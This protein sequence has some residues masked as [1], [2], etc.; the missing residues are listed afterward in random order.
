MATNDTH[1]WVSIAQER[2][3]YINLFKQG[4]EFFPAGRIIPTR[5]MRV[6]PK[7]ISHHVTFGKDAWIKFRQGNCYIYCDIKHR[8]IQTLEQQGESWHIHV[9]PY[10]ETHWS[11]SNKI[12]SL[13]MRG[14]PYGNFLL[15]MH[16]GDFESSVLYKN[17][18]VFGWPELSEH[19]HIKKLVDGITWFKGKEIH[20]DL[21]VKLG[22]EKPTDQP[23]V[24]SERSEKNAITT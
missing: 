19:S 2:D 17:I 22:Y 4:A 5:I 10:R 24:W 1:D 13:F 6:L 21:K 14:N 12:K 16:P 18:E 8:Y 20:D 15:F 23:D 11:R 3:F 7:R 9:K